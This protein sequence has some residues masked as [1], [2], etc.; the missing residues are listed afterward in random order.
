MNG[1]S[2]LLDEKSMALIG[3]MDG[4][5]DRRWREPEG[6]EEPVDELDELDEDE[7]EPRRRIRA[8]LKDT[9]SSSRMVE[10]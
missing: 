2:P 1:T 9:S 5:R 8:L 7:S 10:L 4:Q 3:R 6:F